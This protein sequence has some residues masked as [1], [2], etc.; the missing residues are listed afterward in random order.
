M[1][2]LLA[3][4][5]M[6]GYQLIR[7]V[8]RRTDGSWRLSPGSVYPTLSQ[9]EDEGLVVADDSGGRRSFGLTDAGRAEAASRVDE[10]DAL[11]AEPADPEAQG[12][13]DLAGLVA[14]VAAAAV[15]V[16]AEGTET[17]RE[18]AATLLEDTRRALYRLLAEA[19]GEEA[20]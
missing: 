17:Q 14:Q 15:Q 20:R 8:A 19:D 12:W 5:P 3:Q 16:G 4:E 7:E 11:W 1:L 9:L 6:H 2:G 13:H 10:F 18:R